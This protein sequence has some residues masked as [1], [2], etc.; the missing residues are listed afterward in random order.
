MRNA[1]DGRVCVCVC[2]GIII[3]VFEKAHVRMK[4]IHIMCNGKYMENCW[5]ETETSPKELAG[6][7]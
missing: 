4:R 7:H 3:P 2:A 6:L 1:C 5:A